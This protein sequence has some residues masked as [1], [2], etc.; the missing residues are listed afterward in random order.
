MMHFSFLFDSYQVGNSVEPQFRICVLVFFCLDLCTLLNTI[1]LTSQNDSP[2]QIQKASCWDLLSETFTVPLND[3]LRQRCLNFT[4]LLTLSLP[5]KYTQTYPFGVLQK[6]I[7]RLLYH[8]HQHPQIKI[9]NHRADEANLFGHVP[10]LSTSPSDVKWGGL[11]GQNTH[12]THHM[13]R[14][15]LPPRRPSSPSRHF[16]FPSSPA[17]NN[18]ERIA[19]HKHFLMRMILREY[20][21]SK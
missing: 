13:I 3:V 1:V 4:A 11:Q 14:H 21:P 12:H 8:S 17:P 20:V 15:T 19:L 10:A 18:K 6:E 7:C 16:P 5:D 9:K 2:I